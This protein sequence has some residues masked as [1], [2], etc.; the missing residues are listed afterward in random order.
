MKVSKS[1]PNASEWGRFAEKVNRCI[2]V[3]G[4]INQARNLALCFSLLSPWLGW[5]TKL[6][7]WASGF[8][9]CLPG[10]SLE[11]QALRTFESSW[12]KRRGYTFG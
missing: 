2:V 7:V 12:D 11:S 8:P 5:S 4:L 9:F 6:I 3:A 10:F 1:T